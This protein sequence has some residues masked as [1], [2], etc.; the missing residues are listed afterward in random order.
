MQ[1]NRSLCVSLL[2]LSSRRESD[3]KLDVVSKQRR[4]RELLHNERISVGNGL[5]GFLDAVG[6]EV[7][8]KYGKRKEINRAGT[9]SNVLTPVGDVL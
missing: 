9:E 6:A 2:L 1:P 5:T 8:E 3:G 7:L 4:V